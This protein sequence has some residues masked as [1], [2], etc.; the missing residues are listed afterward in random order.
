V[1]FAQKSIVKVE[2]VT[3]SLQLKTMKVDG[4]LA[5]KDDIG[6]SIAEDLKKKNMKVAMQRKYK[7][8]VAKAF[9]YRRM[10]PDLMG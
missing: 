7:A 2:V 9:K 4:E 10:D 3:G 1:P 8:E 6:T 5:E